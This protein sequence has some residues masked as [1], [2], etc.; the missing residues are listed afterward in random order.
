LG[1]SSA[2]LE[3][4]I[5]IVQVNLH[6]LLCKVSYAVFPRLNGFELD[7][8]RLRQELRKVRNDLTISESKHSQ[9]EGEVDRVTARL[10]G[11]ESDADERQEQIQLLTRKLSA[12]K[13]GR[14]LVSS[15]LGRV[16]ELSAISISK[17]QC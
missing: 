14:E 8:Q 1:L 3:H 7:S 15:E 11:L 5:A 16:K 9:L 2:A 13:A 10:G 12:E 6:E 4:Q 17:S